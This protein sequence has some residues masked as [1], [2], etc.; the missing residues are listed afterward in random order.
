MADKY[1]LGQRGIYDQE[2]FDLVRLDPNASTDWHEDPGA[3]QLLADANA[4]AAMRKEP[5]QGRCEC[6]GYEVVGQYPDDTFAWNTKHSNVRFCSYCGSHLNPDG[7]AT[8][9]PAY[10]PG[11]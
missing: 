8:P 9:N 10:K 3:Q 2:G 1:I 7:T 4:G 11:E 6:G 5:L